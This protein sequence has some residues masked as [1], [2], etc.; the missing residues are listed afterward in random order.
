MDESGPTNFL[1]VP[2]A[3]DIVY[4]GSGPLNLCSGFAQACLPLLILLYTVL[5]IRLGCY[6][7]SQNM[8]LYVLGPKYRHRGGVVMIMPQ[9]KNAHH[10]LDNPHSSSSMVLN[11]GYQCL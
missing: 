2:R 3:R 9:T 6:I 8:H 11:M 5:E 4:L 1:F 10:L 7:L